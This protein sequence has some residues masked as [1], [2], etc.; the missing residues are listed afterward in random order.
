[1]K[2]LVPLGLVLAILA[3]LPSTALVRAATPL[4]GGANQMKAISGLPNVWL[5]N[6]KWRVKLTALAL[7]ASQNFGVYTPAQGHEIVVVRALLRNAM[8]QNAKTVIGA[9]VSDADGVTYASQ[10]VFDS[11]PQVAVNEGDAVLPPGAAT[12]VQLPIDVPVDFVPVSVLL[13]HRFNDA[14]SFR[15]KVSKLTAS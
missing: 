3:A 11:N 8:N 15:I 12:H 7:P 13:V 10:I 1:M 9:F 14:K 5:F 6:G 2:R 4:K